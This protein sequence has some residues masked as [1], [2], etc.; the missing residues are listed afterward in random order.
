MEKQEEAMLKAEKLMEHLQTLFFY[1]LSP[2][3]CI[4]I[5]RSSFVAPLPRRPRRAG[6]ERETILIAVS[7]RVLRFDHDIA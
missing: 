3:F 6:R 2:V 4:L 1:H 7:L 5:C